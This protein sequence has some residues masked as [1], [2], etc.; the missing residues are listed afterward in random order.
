[1]PA[2]PKIPR[3]EMIIIAVFS[4]NANFRGPNNSSTASSPTDPYLTTN[5]IGNILSLG[6]NN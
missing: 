1:M 6:L 2:H 4:P 5:I 3:I